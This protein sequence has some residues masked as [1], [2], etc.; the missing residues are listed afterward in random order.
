MEV[1]NLRERRLAITGI[2]DGADLTR[3][4]D[5][6]SLAVVYPQAL[7]SPAAWN[8]STGTPDLAF[9]TAMLDEIEGDLC[10]D[11]NRIFMSGFS[12][13]AMLTSLAMC[14]PLSAR[15]AA[16]APVAGMLNPAGCAPQRAVPAY[17]GGV[18]V[19]VYDEQS[20][21]VDAVA[22]VEPAKAAPAPPPEPAAHAA[23]VLAGRL[24]AR[25]VEIIDEAKLRDLAGEAAA[26]VSKEPTPNLRR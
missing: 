7:N 19:D 6:R 14:G 20:G 9:V 1:A 18:A 25:H 2:A 5:A 8:L 13:G 21:E 26:G 23:D 17:D 10:V 3:V 12:M 16:V 4:L 22:D 24:G 11:T 15:I